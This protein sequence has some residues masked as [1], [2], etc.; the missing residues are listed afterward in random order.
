MTSRSFQFAFNTNEVKDIKTTNTP[1]AA[2]VVLK[3]L[4]ILVLTQLGTGTK[5]YRDSVPITSVE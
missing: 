3:L 2:P 1:V 4:D 5:N